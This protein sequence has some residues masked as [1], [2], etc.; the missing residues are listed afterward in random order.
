MPWALRSVAA[1]I[2]EAH[3]LSNVNDTTVGVFAGAGADRAADADEAADADDAADADAADKPATAIVA[4]E[5]AA[6]TAAARLNRK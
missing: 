5:T 4:A 1:V 3:W 6:T 2:C